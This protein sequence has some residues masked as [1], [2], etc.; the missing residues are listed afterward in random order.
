MGG[1][2]ETSVVVEGGEEVG[3]EEEGIEVVEG[4]DED[5]GEGEQG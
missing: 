1:G 3:F 5:T 4:G 2:E